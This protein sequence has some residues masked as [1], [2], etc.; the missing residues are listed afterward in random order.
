MGIRPRVLDPLDL[1][2][3]DDDDMMLGRVARCHRGDLAF[4]SV[5]NPLK[6]QD[7]KGDTEF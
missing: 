4:L 3:D 6:S 1:A 2:R 5:G 7:K